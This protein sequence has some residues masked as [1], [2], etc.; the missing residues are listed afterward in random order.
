MVAGA[1]KVKCEIL[2]TVDAVPK[3]SEGRVVFN[4]EG[5]FG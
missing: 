2:S 5:L 4:H 3:I 1:I